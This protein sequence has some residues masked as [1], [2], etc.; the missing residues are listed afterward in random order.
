MRPEAEALT[1]DPRFA[2]TV[3]VE[4]DGTARPL[5]FAD[6]YGLVASLDTITGAP[7]PVRTAF[8]RALHCFLYSWF[9]YEMMVIAEA[10]AIASFELALKLKLN[11]PADAPPLHGLNQRLKAAIDAGHL[12]RP[13][14]AQQPDEYLI[15]RSIRNEL[16]HGSGDV[17]SPALVVEVFV[18]CGAFIGQ[19]YPG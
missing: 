14:P 10:Q 9:D 5:T 6:H 3:A 2:T 13:D 19:L 15:L 11:R 12:P 18:R 16:A 8:Q 17:H 7:A 1:P 4:A